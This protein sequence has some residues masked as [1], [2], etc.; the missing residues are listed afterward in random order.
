M[1]F[2]V[3]LWNEFMVFLDENKILPIAVAFIIVIAAAEFFKSLVD[4]VLMPIVAFFLPKGDWQNAVL[5][6]GPVSIKWGMFLSS[7][8]YFLIIAVFIFLIVK[9][10]HKQKTVPTPKK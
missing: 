1:V 5:N 8:L 2:Y 6:I 4:N 7:L 3:G 10:A 9:Y